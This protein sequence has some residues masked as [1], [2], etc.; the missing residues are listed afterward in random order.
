MMIKFTQ[1]CRAEQRHA[2]EL[3]DTNV[4]TRVQD[5]V[6]TP[7]RAQDAF[8]LLRAVH[9][10]KPPDSAENTSAP[11]AGKP[12]ANLQNAKPRQ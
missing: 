10:I 9:L 12:A 6:A 2:E 4:P 8:A 3:D 1:S 11:F 5:E 7:P